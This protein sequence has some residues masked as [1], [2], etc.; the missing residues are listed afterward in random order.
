MQRSGSTDDDHDPSS[1]SIAE[2]RAR[3]LD[4]LAPLEETERLAAREAR[5][6]VL[7]AD[8]VAPMDVPSFRASAMDG[9][10]L[11]HA[12][13]AAP[14]RIVGRSLAGHPHEGPLPA[15]ACVRITTGARVPDDA[16]TVVQQE[17]AHVEDD[18]VRVTTP[19][20]PGLHVR[21]IGS[22][23]VR[24]RPLIA[25]GTWLAASE[26]ALLAAHGV[27]TLDVVRPL[28][29]AL[30]STG[31]ELVEPGAATGPGQIHD[32]NR[33]LLDALLAES[34]IA[35][36]DLGICRDSAEALERTLDAA[37]GADVVVSSGGVSVGEADHVRAALAARG[38]VELWK[39][40]M[41]PGRPLTFGRT[42]DGQA[43]FGLPGN[44]V[45][46]AITALLFLR[47]AL[48]R[49]RGLLDAPS[50]P[51]AARLDG[52][53]AKRPG[54]VEYQRG[55][56]SVEADGSVVVR[57]TGA[58]DSHVLLSLQRANCLIELP[59]ASS[60]ARAGETVTVHPFS[61][62]ARSPL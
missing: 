2:A 53:L 24:G 7:A 29:V 51:L 30:F 33:A 50:P 31:D 9:Y 57:S 27:T 1:L 35:V 22:D 34:G 58:Q 11:R 45:S 61:R 49:L 5:G 15:G 8:V 40:A 18:L 52:D 47:P 46:A 23:S 48:D 21:G 44:P 20:E 17:N 13:H 42:T 10:A 16:D 62:Y 54:R 19:P 55:F 60:G 56:V 25:K 28:R 36:D 38:R 37:H 59:L 39:I 12:E 26:L 32:A 4:A 41:K 6:R 3:I 14:L 43:F